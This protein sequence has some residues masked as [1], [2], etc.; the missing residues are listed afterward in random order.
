[1]YTDLTHRQQVLVNQETYEMLT[2][3]PN[4]NTLHT[5]V[6]FLSNIFIIKKRMAKLTSHEFKNLNQFIPF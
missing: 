2:E 3:N 6:E 4:R 5:Q 1:M